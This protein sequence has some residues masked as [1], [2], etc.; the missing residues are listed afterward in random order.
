MLAHHIDDIDASE[1][2]L[3]EVLRN[4]PASLVRQPGLSAPAGP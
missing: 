3:D 2:L 4:H 1:Q